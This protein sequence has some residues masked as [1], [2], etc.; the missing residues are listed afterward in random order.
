MSR[1][2]EGDG[3]LRQGGGRHQ[4]WLGDTARRRGQLIGRQLSAR[5]LEK[6][7]A[8]VGREPQVLGQ[9]LGDLARGAAGVRL[10]LADRFERAADA[11]GQGVLRQ[12]A[13]LA[14]ALEPLAQREDRFHARFRSLDA[15]ERG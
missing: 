11:L 8:L 2:E 1:E 12:V 13:G 7:G 10:D 9:S 3:T 15:D 5:G 14:A 4:R 6:G